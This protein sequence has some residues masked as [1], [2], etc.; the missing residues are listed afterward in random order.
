MKSAGALTLVVAEMETTPS[1]SMNFT[2]ESLAS[3]AACEGVSSAVKPDTR[4]PGKPT[5]KK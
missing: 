3:V 5:H 4:E 2:A 1:S